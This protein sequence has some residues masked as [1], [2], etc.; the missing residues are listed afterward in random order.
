MRIFKL[1]HG[2]K[3]KKVRVSMNDVPA[4]LRSFFCS[5]SRAKLFRA[6]MMRIIIEAVKLYICLEKYNSC[7]D[8]FGVE[9]YL[10]RKYLSVE[11]LEFKP[12]EQNSSLPFLIAPLARGKISLTRINAYSHPV[13]VRKIRSFR[14]N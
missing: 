8:P 10:S 9:P 12:I 3:K 1:F 4:S 7:Q 11:K 2:K 5:M 14:N 6:K 13:T